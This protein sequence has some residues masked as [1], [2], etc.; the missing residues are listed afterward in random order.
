MLSFCIKDYVPS[1]N[2]DKGLSFANELLIKLKSVKNYSLLNPFLSDEEGLEDNLEEED[3]KN[4][5]RDSDQISINKQL[6]EEEKKRRA[7]ELWADLCSS[8]KSDKKTVSNNLSSNSSNNNLTTTTHS[9]IRTT[10]V[11]PSST[12]LT[13][14]NNSTS[15]KKIKVTKEYEFAGE[16]IKIE[17]EIDCKDQQQNAQQINKQ[18]APLKRGLDISDLVANLG[19]KQKLSTLNKTKLDWS[20]FKKEEGIEDDLKNH[21]KNKNSYVE[22]KAFLERTDHKQFELEKSIRDKNRNRN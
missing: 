19:K 1:D 22:R 13:S 3:D 15:S 9:S 16:R 18:A 7:D 17:E 12:N 8:T 5:Q 10:N 21:T 2:E 14:S 6:S 20:L 11:K 4:E